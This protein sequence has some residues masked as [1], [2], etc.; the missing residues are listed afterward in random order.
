VERAPDPGIIPGPSAYFCAAVGESVHL[1]TSR[2]LDTYQWLR[3]GTEIPGATSWQYETSTPGEYSVMVTVEHCATT[4]DPVVVVSNSCARYEVSSFRVGDLPLRVEP[5][6]ISIWVSGETWAKAYNVYADRLGSWYAPSAASGSHCAITDWA[7]HPSG[8]IS[9][10]YAVP[11]GSWIV[12]TGSNE[13]GEGPA[14][15]LEPLLDRTDHGSWEL[16]GPYP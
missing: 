8:G 2:D 6:G 4:A 14:G 3:D 5:G 11:A 1:S 12:V 13:H 15:Y 9:L 10:D 7:V 16:C